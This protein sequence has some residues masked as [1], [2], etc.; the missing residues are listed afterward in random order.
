MEGGFAKTL[1]PPGGNG[2]QRKLAEG[3]KRTRPNGEVGVERNTKVSAW[4]R[5]SF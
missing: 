2:N 5:P 1:Y 4:D 3:K